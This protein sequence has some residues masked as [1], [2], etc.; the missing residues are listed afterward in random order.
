MPHL[1]L[2]LRAL[3]RSPVEPAD[4]ASAVAEMEQLDRMRVALASTLEG[5]SDAPTIEMMKEVCKPVGMKAMAIG[6][7][8]GWQVRQVASKYRNPDHA[9]SNAQERDVIDM[10]QRHPAITGLW[11][12]VTAE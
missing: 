2:P 7:E 4:L 12:P 9:P 10:F 1:L 6:K 11:Q 3:V 8:H 5:Q